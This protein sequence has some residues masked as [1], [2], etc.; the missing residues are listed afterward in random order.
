MEIA[1]LIHHSGSTKPVHHFECLIKMPFAQRR[2]LSL[3]NIRCRS[4]SHRTKC[5]CLDIALLLSFHD[6]TAA[7]S[8]SQRSL[9]SNDPDA[10]SADDTGTDDARKL[11]ERLK[12][13]RKEITERRLK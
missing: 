2:S 13:E 7:C 5:L 8:I 1:L 12:Q 9:H 4:F 3:M 10:Q 6:H 11:W